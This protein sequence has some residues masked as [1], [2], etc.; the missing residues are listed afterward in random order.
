M[1]QH[2]IITDC[3]QTVQCLNAKVEHDNKW[4]RDKHSV[5]AKKV[6]GINTPRQKRDKQK[7][8][9]QFFESTIVNCGSGL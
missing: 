3:P 9:A 4:C 2:F 8:F 6:C 7:C 5:I 1:N